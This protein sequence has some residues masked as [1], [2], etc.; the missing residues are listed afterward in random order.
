MAKEDGVLFEEEQARAISNLDGVT[1]AESGLRQAILESEDNVIGQV[2]RLEKK[3]YSLD[4]IEKIEEGMKEVDKIVENPKQFIK[5]ERDI[6]PAVKIKRVSSESIQH[7]ASHSYLV[8]EVDE[9]SNVTPDKLLSVENEDEVAIYENRFVKTLILK[10]YTF[11]TVR[12][13]YLMENRDA[14]DSE[15]LTLHST[16]KIGMVEYQVDTRIE[17][18]R[19]SENEEDLNRENEVMAR[20]FKIRDHL[21]YY[22]GSSFMAALKTAR[23][24]RNP[25][26]MTNMIVKNPHY[27]KAYE[28]WEYLDN[29]DA[30]GLSFDTLERYQRFDRTYRQQIYSYIELGIFLMR[31]HAL[32]GN[33]I[34]PGPED[35]KETHEP[36]VLLELDD[37]A[38]L[39]DKFDYHA[40]ERYIVKPKEKGLPPYTS[41]EIKE[42]KKLQKER[43]E[44][45]KLFRKLISEYMSGLRKESAEQDAREE[46]EARREESERRIRQK[47]E[48]YL[49]RLQVELQLAMADEDREREERVLA[50]MRQ[51]A[52]DGI[53]NP[54]RYRVEDLGDLKERLSAKGLRIVPAG[55]VVIK[56]NQEEPEGKSKKRI[57]KAGRVFIR[58]LDPDDTLNDVTLGRTNRMIRR[59]KED[60]D[61]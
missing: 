47:N 43:V 13:D 26:S 50:L 46:E 28:L 30:L 57:V 18:R 61:E 7:L 25:I 3:E 23:P 9:D 22:M 40:F 33:V 52:L 34:L 2:L 51:Y 58:H 17:A 12:Y 44:K 16:S 49:H 36:K 56:Q 31:S 21:A 32:N 29:Y 45:E 15:V 8:R 5:Q 41:E 38:F 20:I 48:E 6:I 60:S 37:E 35:R 14:H 24:V 54:H 27:H 19:A 42:M 55:T 39:D 1:S 59:K 4:W 53:R 11:I 10:L